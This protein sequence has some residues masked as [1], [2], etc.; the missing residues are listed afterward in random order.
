M[1]INRYVGEQY[2]TNTG[3]KNMVSK[4]KDNNPVLSTMMLKSYCVTDLDLSYNFSLKR[5]GV[6][7]ATFGVSFYNLFSAKYDNNGWAGPKYT[8]VNNK[9]TAINTWGPYDTDAAGFAPSAPFNFMAH[10]SLNF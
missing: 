3:I 2:L 5:L 8:K 6:K 10:L 7:D 9:L 4:D 1:L